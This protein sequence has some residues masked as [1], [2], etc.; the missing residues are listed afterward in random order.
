MFFCLF[1]A[2]FLLKIVLSKLTGIQYYKMVYSTEQI[3]LWQVVSQ[4]AQDQQRLFIKYLIMHSWNFSKY[5]W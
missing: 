4:R 2:L 3:Y 5:S 1:Y